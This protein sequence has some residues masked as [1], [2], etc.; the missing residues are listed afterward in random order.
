MVKDCARAR[1]IMKIITALK[2]RLLSFIDHHNS[3][4]PEKVF[5][6]I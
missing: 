1:A 2:P 6:I 5:S 3:A 4:Q